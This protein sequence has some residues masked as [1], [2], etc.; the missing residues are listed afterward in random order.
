MIHAL[1]VPRAGAQGLSLSLADAV[2]LAVANNP[3][4]ATARLKST[5]A[6]ARER[7]SRGELLP[8]LSAS[9]LRSTHT[10]N[11]ATLG[12]AFNAPD[13]TPFFNPDGEILG[14]VSSL[15]FKARLAQPIVD[16]AARERLRAAGNAA[17]AGTADVEAAEEQVAEVAALAYVRVQRAVAHVGAAS[18]DSALASDLVSAAQDQLQAGTGVALDVTR[19]RAQ[20]AT[21]RAQLLAA[22][23]ERDRARL[24]LLRILGIPADSAVVL[25]DSTVAPL[26]VENLDD[27]AAIS[28]ANAQRPELRGTQARIDEA[29]RKERAV[30]MERLPTLSAFLEDGPIQGEGGSYLPTYTWGVQLSVPVFDGFRREGRISE[31]QAQRQEAQVRRRDLEAQIALDVRSA[32]LDLESAAEQVAAARDRLSLADDEVQ[33]ARDRFR[34]GVTGNLEVISASLTLSAARSQLVDVLAAYAG[35]RVALARAV[36]AARRI[37]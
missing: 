12:F 23:S 20:A 26:D 22:R 7:Q 17:D 14:P 25:T 21:V 31:M 36:G 9:V 30:R 37:R 6:L 3:A 10:M 19:A 35:A 1:A 16:A 11:T 24:A 32:R 4:T 5:E 2:R 27:R 29:A 13:G 33:Q 34:A 18:A 15:D 8:S 28:E